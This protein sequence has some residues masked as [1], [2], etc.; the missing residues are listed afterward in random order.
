LGFQTAGRVV[1]A[2]R[3]ELAVYGE[4]GKNYKTTTIARA[5]ASAL[6]YR[7][8]KKKAAPKLFPE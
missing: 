1:K 5:K 7:N 4:K 6:K 8:A 3:L 2:A